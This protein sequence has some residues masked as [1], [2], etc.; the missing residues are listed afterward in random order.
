VGERRTILPTCDSAGPADLPSCIFLIYSALSSWKVAC[1]EYQASLWYLLAHLYIASA[2]CPP[3]GALLPTLG[4]GAT[5]SWW[6][7]V[8]NRDLGDFDI[9]SDTV[10]WAVCALFWSGE[11]DSLLSLMTW[12]Q[13]PLHHTCQWQTKHLAWFQS[14]EVCISEG[15]VALACTHSLGKWGAAPRGSVGSKPRAVEQAFT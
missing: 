10:P 5:C 7:E 12:S 4:D 13:G 6:Q 2:P 15:C 1:L 9:D 14:F 3:S 11:S 8:E